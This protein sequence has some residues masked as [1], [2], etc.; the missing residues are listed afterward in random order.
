MFK[1]HV[2]NTFSLPFHHSF[3]C[4]ILKD[5]WPPSCPYRMIR[6]LIDRK[7]ASH[8]TNSPQ[9]AQYFAACP[10]VFAV[11]RHRADPGD[12]VVQPPE[13]GFHGCYCFFS[14]SAGTAEQEANRV[15]NVRCQM[16]DDNFFLSAKKKCICL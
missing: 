5:N 16:T 13:M 9:F 3:V 11:I 12:E 4:A 14:Q 8:V 1:L 7:K 6:H 15:E 2:S 10:R